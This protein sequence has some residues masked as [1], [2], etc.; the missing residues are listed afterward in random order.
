MSLIDG[1]ALRPLVV[2]EL[3]VAGGKALHRGV[4]GARGGHHAVLVAAKENLLG[5]VAG[6]GG[7]QKRGV[8]HDLDAERG[9][10][11]E[12]EARRAVGAGAVRHAPHQGAVARGP[13]GLGRDAGLSAPRPAPASALAEVSASGS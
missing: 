8:A 12:H 9:R 4:R 7:V 13:K 3:L 10:Q 2:E 5:K 6:R 11:V 1:L